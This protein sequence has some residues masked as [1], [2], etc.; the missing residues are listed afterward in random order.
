MYTV[1]EEWFDQNADRAYP[2]ADGVSRLD[3]DGRLLDNSFLV[4]ARIAAPANYLST[5]FYIHTISSFGHGL[6]VTIGVDG[7]GD[8]ASVTVPL[9]G[10]QDFTAYTLAP[11]PGHPD[12]GG[13]LV[14]GHEAAL[15]AASGNNFTF[16]P[17]ATQLLPTVIFPAAPAV[18]SITIIDAFGAEQRLTGAVVLQAGANA[19]LLVNGQDLEFSM[20][21][22]VVLED[23]CA[24]RDTG[25]NLRTAI[26]SINGVTPDLN[27]ELTIQ[28]VGC[29]Q[30]DAGTNEL[31]LRDNC[32]QPC[33]GTPEVQ[34]LQDAARNIDQFMSQQAN[35]SAELEAVLRALQ[36]YLV[37]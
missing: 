14:F 7:I 28:G 32:A 24:C 26:K 2:L 19:A 6:V 11:L 18:T 8:V 5:K 35:K 33:C 17:A 23:P 9:A 27:G 29:L 12:V 1:N 16:L 37:G 31:K 34:L 20:E 36:A 15:L 3:V 21:D 13:T 22:G 30:I 10:F 25:G 4:D